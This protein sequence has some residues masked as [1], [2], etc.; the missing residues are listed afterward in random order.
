MSDAVDC[1]LHRAC[2][3]APPQPSHLAGA[4][5]FEQICDGIASVGIA[6]VDEFIPAPH[7]AALAADARQRGAAGAFRPA[8]IGRGTARIQQTETRGD[9]ILWLDDADLAPPVRAAIAALNGLRA[10][11]NATLF[12]G[13]CTF[14]SHYAIYPPGAVYLRHRDRFR[15]DDGRVL[16]CVLY[17]NADWG[18]A[19]G[20]A[21]RI[22]GDDDVER[23]ILPTAGTLVC[24]RS[25]RFDH[26]VLA[27]TRERLSLTGWFKRRDTQPE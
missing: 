27:A 12:L 16:S 4:G 5:A 3:A 24:F 6:V 19:Q 1:G 25:E 11:L 26:E 2:V 9:R 22:F 21:L 23:D 18:A 8:G 17:L 20:G 15:D 14:E 13:L 10:A 7:I